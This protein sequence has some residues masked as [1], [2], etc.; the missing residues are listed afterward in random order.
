MQKQLMHIRTITNILALTCTLMHA[1]Y[2]HTYLLL[3]ANAHMSLSFSCE[4]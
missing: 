1:V 2:I 4:T 3:N